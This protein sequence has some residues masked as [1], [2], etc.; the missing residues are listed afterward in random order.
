M[1][2]QDILKRLTGRVDDEGNAL[3]ARREL[4]RQRIVS[5]ASSALL[6]TGYKNL[7]VDDVARDAEV[8]RATLYA[9]FGSKAHLLFAALSEESLAQLQT[10]APLF[11]GTRS[12]EDRLRDWVKMSFAYVESAPLH[13]RL[14][15]DQDHEVM[16][17][18]TEHE[19]ARAALSLQPDLDKARLLVA[20][21]HD[22]FPRVY[23]DEEA[24]EVAALISSLGH[25]APALSGEQARFGL[26]VERLSDLL[27]TL[28]VDGLAQRGR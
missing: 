14:A 24:Q 18:L 8:T 13:A 11:D 6:A 3:G 20:L 16:R 17:I 28:L 10:V 23:S 5:A 9:Y 15:R 19:L 2:V 22:A 7:R 27:A 12:A 25:M 4:T 1:S 21:I 26:S